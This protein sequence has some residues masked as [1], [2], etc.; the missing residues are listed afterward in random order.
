MCVNFYHILLKLIRAELQAKIPKQS[1][2][3]GESDVKY[4]ER[5]DKIITDI[6][7]QEYVKLTLIKYIFE[8]LPEK[9]IK[10]V[11][12]LFEDNDEDKSSDILSQ[13]RFIERFLEKS[14]ILGIDKGENK[15]IKILRD[16]VYPYFKE[17]FDTH[18]KNLKKIT[19]GYLSIIGDLSI[20][21][22][23]YNAV[24]DKKNKEK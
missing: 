3:S 23:I 1:G 17:Y 19:D 4:E 13:L 12:K 7:N 24:L 20:K 6:C 18:I 8:I 5:I 14:Q 2:D 22:E 15:I 9:I 10:I 11:L 16:Y 21:L